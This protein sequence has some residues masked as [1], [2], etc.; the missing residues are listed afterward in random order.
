VQTFV[1][2]YNTVV[3]NGHSTAGFA[4]QTATNSLLQG[5]QAVRSSLDQLGQFMAA[6]VPGSSGAYT[7]LASVGVTLNDDGTLAFDSTKL[8]S[9]LLSDPS[10][11]ERL[12]VTDSTNGSTGVMKSIGSMLDSM[13]NPTGLIQAEIK[14]FAARNSEIAD[15]VASEQR[16]IANYQ[17]QLQAQFTQMNATLAQYKQIFASLNASS[18]NS[19]SGSTNNT[20]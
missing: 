14:G 16:R 13:T 3:N 11:V 9:G 8:A 15:Q 6:Q 4:A 19:S 2:A 10:S 12:F 17:T 7:T 1:T 5:D 18:G 20:L